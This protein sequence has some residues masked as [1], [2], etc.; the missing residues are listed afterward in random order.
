[1]QMEFCNRHQKS[2]YKNAHMRSWP[3][4]C[5]YQSS[6]CQLEKQYILLRR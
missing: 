4:C 5:E 6:S 1:M 2:N 3:D